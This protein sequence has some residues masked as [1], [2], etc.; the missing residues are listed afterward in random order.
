MAISADEVRVAGTG[1]VYTAPKGTALP[2]TVDSALP[3]D[4]TDLG[5][6]TTDGVSFTFSRETEDLAAWQGDKIRVLSLSEPKMVEFTLM[7]TD[8]AVLETAFGGGT[9]ETDAG[10]TTYT[11]PLRGENVERS[12]VIEFLDDDITY[13]YAFGRVQQE[14]DVNFVLTREGA[15][16]YPVT[17]GV[18]EA[19]PAY[20][21]ITNDPAMEAPI[22]FGTTKKAPTVLND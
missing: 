3:A 17:F 2:T 8:A 14:G 9:V 15:V 10:V 5:Y 18:L 21:I 4:W 12:M 7:Q 20:T 11:P 19:T 16:E 13:R 1:R 22:I 6:V